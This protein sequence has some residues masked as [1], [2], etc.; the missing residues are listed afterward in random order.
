[1]ITPI[2]GA[3]DWMPQEIRGLSTDTKPTNVPNG[4][5]FFEMDTFK[6]YF[7]DADSEIWR[8]K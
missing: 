7:W 3:E 4:T 1:M 5:A 8:T 2:R 6:V